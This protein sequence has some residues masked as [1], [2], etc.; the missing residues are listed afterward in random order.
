MPCGARSVAPDFGVRRALL[1]QGPNGPFFRR[2]ADELE[3]LG[4]EVTKVNFHA[5]DAFFFRGR[6]AIPFRGRPAE[7]PAF[8]ERLMSERG[9][10]GLYVFGDGRPYH[11]VAIE[12]ARRKNLPVYVFE[13]GY[14]RPDW[15][16]LEPGGVNGYS[17]MPRDPAFFRAYGAAHSAPERAL[18]VGKTFGI[19]ALY[20]TLLA[21]AATLA[22]FRYP[23]YRHHRSINSW[24]QMTLWIVGAFRKYWY[25]FKERKVLPDL[26]RARNKRYFLVALQ[27]YCDYQVFHSPYKSVEDFIEEVVQ[28]FAEHASS[29]DSLVLKHHPMD[30]AYK[31]YSRL[32]KRLARRHGL[33]GRLIYV[34]DLHLPTLLRRAKGAVMINSTVGLQSISYGTPVKVLGDAVYDMPGLTYQGSLAEFWRNPGSVDRALYEGFRCYLLRNNQHNGSFA[35]PLPG[36]ATPTGILWHREPL[37][38]HAEAEARDAAMRAVDG[39]AHSPSGAR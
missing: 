16:T 20:A 26:V 7:L 32:L 33:E 28:S 5:G 12:I 30:R 24:V 17:S 13:E 27:V 10:D 4:V 15:I 19:G 34:H 36:V 2:F 39:H 3:Q 25:R 37:D 38:A 29:D 21:L 31:D 6:R 9:I 1:L 18:P 14:L 35:R 23:H 22:F 8:L 11:R